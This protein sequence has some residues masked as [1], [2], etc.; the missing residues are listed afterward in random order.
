[1][2][3]D[4]DSLLKCGASPSSSNHSHGMQPIH[5]AALRGHTDIVHRLL[6]AGAHP[7]ARDRCRRRTPARWARARGHVELAKALDRARPGVAICD[8][9]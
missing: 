2:L 9:L 7:Q 6:D 1:M 5:L 3:V 8:R 4:V